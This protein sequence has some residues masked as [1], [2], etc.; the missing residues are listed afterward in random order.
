MK[1]L[2]TYIPALGCSA[3]MAVCLVVMCG[4]RLRRRTPGVEADLAPTP[5]DASRPDATHVVP[6][7]VLA[8]LVALR[9]EVA[10]LRASAPSNAA[11]TDAPAARG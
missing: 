6:G 1:T 4:S 7:E 10:Q 9:T 3:M 11:A 5:A 2:F 8:E